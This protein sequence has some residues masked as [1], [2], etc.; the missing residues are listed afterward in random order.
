M[1]TDSTAVT[2]LVH[3]PGRGAMDWAWD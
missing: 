2:S 1:F 3:R